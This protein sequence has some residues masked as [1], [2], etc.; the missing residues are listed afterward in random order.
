M[1][2]LWFVHSC[3]YTHQLERAPWKVD[4]QICY[5]AF[6]SC[7][8]LLFISL[9]NA[10]NFYL[11]Y[12]HYYLYNLWCFILWLNICWFLLWA[13]FCPENFNI[14]WN[15]S[16]FVLDFI[17]SLWFQDH[18]QWNKRAQNALKVRSITQDYS[19]FIFSRINLSSTWGINCVVSKMT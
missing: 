2:L 4:C 3:L 7:F 8:C 18:K 12:Y 15:E 5:R 10:D 19:Y 9:I 17:Y 16:D 14:A 6:L 11:H 13:L 1:V